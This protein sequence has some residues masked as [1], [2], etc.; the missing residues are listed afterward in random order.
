MKSFMQAAK[1]F[2]RLRSLIFIQYCGF[3]RKSPKIKMRISPDSVKTDDITKETISEL[4]QRVTN[5]KKVNA[6]MVEDDEEEPLEYEEYTENLVIR[7]PKGFLWGFG[8]TLTDQAH[9]IH[10]LHQ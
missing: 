5:S 9:G 10:S 4:A 7:P 1:Q 3:A 8:G 6:K 2:S